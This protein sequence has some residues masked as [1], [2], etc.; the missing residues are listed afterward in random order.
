MNFKIL[1]LS[2]F[3]FGCT[4]NANHPLSEFKL[5]EKISA[6]FQSPES[7][8]YDKER[9][10]IY[11]SNG[12]WYAKNGQGFISKLSK[13]GEILNLHWLKN[14]NRPTGMAIGENQ[15][16]SADIDKLRVFDLDS[17]EQT[18]TYPAP[19]ENPMLNDVAISEKGEV[20][21]TSSGKHGVYHLKNDSLKL[22][23]Q[24]DSL[25]KYANGIVIQKDKLIVAGWDI[26]EISLTDY[27]I[28][29]RTIN[30][31]VTDFDGLAI[32]EKGILFCTQV[33]EE[34]KLWQINSDGKAE[35]VFKYPKYLADFDLTKIGDGRFLIA[36][37]NHEEKTYSVLS[38]SK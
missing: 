8:I 4:Q 17:G 31:P 36:S 6:D 3:L 30:P 29:K 7:V 24:H 21:V 22:V 1:I 32:D 20:Y 38:I 23:F 35:L 37:G 16:F 12:I 2:L 13:T 14:L 28:K 34:G 10:M 19:E 27:S 18:K 33:S 25:L 11:V 26:S 9:E 15:L 5:T